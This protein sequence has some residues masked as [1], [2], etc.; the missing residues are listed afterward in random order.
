[1]KNIFEKGSIF[2]KTKSL[3]YLY[4]FMSPNKSKQFQLIYKH[5][6]KTIVMK[7]YFIID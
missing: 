4:F 2:R 7:S 6:K 3:K 1:M 5:F